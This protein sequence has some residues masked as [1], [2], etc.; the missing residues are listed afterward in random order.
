MNK[1]VLSVAFGFLAGLLLLR[2]VLAQD[3]RYVTDFSLPGPDTTI[4]SLADFQDKKAVVVVF[5][6]SHC[7]WAVKYQDRL[8]QLW[9]SFA[10]RE[11][12]FVA[13]NS[14]DTTVSRRDAMARMSR[15]MAYPFPYLKDDDQAVARLFEATKTPEVFVLVPEKARFKVVYQG[16]IDDNP[17]A[18][19]A[20]YLQDAL[21]GLLAG[22]VPAPAFVDPTGCDIK[23]REAGTPRR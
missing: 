14:N 2:P 16:K 20:H 4:V 6:S 8:T 15:N 7:A 1:L 3:V 19:Q 9:D 10:P 11:V 17:L 12:A 22:K 5:T 21:E 23:W 13:I 18:P